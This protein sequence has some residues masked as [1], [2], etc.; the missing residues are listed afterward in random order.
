MPLERRLE[1]LGR[2]S[3]VEW[4]AAAVLLAGAGVVWIAAYALT[5]GLF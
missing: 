1:T 2:P 3:A 4:F 5:R